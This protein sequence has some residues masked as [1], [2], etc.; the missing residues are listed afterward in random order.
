MLTLRANRDCGAVR[1]RRTGGGQESHLRIVGVQRQLA[2]AP[3]VRERPVW[4]RAR[5]IQQRVKAVATGTADDGREP[6]GNLRTALVASVV[7][8]VHVAVTLQYEI[9]LLV[10]GYVKERLGTAGSTFAGRVVI[11]RREPGMVP[12]QHR[13]LGSVERVSQEVH[14]PAAGRTRRSLVRGGS[15]RGSRVEYYR[16]PVAVGHVVSVEAGG[17]RD[18]NRRRVG[19]FVPVLLRTHRRGRAVVVVV[20]VRRPRLVPKGA[21]RGIVDLIVLIRTVRVGVVPGGEDAPCST[22][23]LRPYKVTGRLVPAAARRDVSRCL[24]HR[25]RP[26]K[27][28]RAGTH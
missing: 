20:A 27:T 8:L 25:P 7:A 18:P 2:D 28:S 6:T 19:A 24:R 12:E 26:R 23:E 13:V 14:L 22:A 1:A 5:A 4:R 21:P 11:A 10:V 3:S 9:R 17:V 16:P 15:L